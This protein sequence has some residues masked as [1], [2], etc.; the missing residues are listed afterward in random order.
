MNEGNFE[1]SPDKVYTSKDEALEELLGRPPAE[2]FAEIEESLGNRASRK[3]F[4][5]NE[6]MHRLPDGINLSKIYK[7]GEEEL[8]MSDLL[9][10]L[11]EQHNQE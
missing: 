4:F 3:A 6:C 8:T 5:N 2:F 7:V 1:F 9:D 10:Y 11:F